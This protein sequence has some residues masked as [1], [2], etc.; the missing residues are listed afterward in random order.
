M[1]YYILRLKTLHS[2]TNLDECNTF[3]DS[4]VIVARITYNLSQFQYVMFVSGRLF[5]SQNQHLSIF[6]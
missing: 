3:N 2:I 5:F 4:V 1:K 6:C